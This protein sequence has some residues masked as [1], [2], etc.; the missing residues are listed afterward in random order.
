MLEALRRSTSG[1]VAKIFLGLLVLS[2]AVW[3][4][5]DI[6]TGYRG[7]DVAEVGNTPIT[8]DEFRTSLQQ[9]IQQVSRQV[10]TY[11][12]MDQARSIGLDN[13]VLGRLM[14]EAALNDEAKT[15]GLG[16]TDAVIAE[17]IR[18]DPA[19]QAPGGQFDRSYFEQVLR[20]N[21]FSEAGFV[22]QQ[23]NVLMRQMIAEAVGGEL[24]A[25]E[26]L[27]KAI[28]RF[29]NET[30]SAEFIVITPAM[31]DAVPDPTEEQ[32]RSYY[33]E[34][35]VDF[36]APEYRKV[37]M[38]AIAPAEL[39]NDIEVSEEELRASYD[40]DPSRFGAP[41]R[42]AIERIVFSDAAAAEA[43]RTEIEAGKSF[44]DVAADLGLT[45]EDRKLGTLTKDGILDPAIGEAAFDL[46]I[47]EVSQPVQGTFGPVLVR[48]TE[49]EAGLN[50]SF[51]DVRDEIRIDLATQKAKDQ[52]LDV[53]DAI[54]DDRAAGMTLAEISQKQGLPYREVE[55]IDSNG[56][57]PDESPVSGLPESPQFLSEVLATDIGVEADPLQTRGDGWA[58]L[59][60]LDITPSRDLAF[61]EARDKVAEA[62]RANETRK[63]VEVKAKDIAERVRGGAGF[64]AVAEELGTTSGLVGPIARGAT[65]GPFGTPA[66]QLLF[67]T[68]EGEV[69]STAAAQAPQRVVF[70]V[71]DIDIPPF[72][73]GEAADYKT[74]IEDGISND[75][76][77]Q[78][79]QELEKRIGTSINQEALRVALGE[80]SL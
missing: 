52:I 29:R 24:R 36:R 35:K 10:G 76:L 3:G 63:A 9:E 72:K 67:T 41:E 45:E 20:S 42:R 31:V 79:L 12:T 22:Y 51:E 44:E 56:L 2:F 80:S 40:A 8:I 49:I 77:S 57:A 60:V 39:A 69:N 74:E 38:L 7:T 61:E 70:R 47:G 58:W 75:L 43:A 15:M 48:V 26:V 1:W 78:Y 65:D 62:W 50:K 11:L 55:A 37:A 14:A 27:E 68:P 25:P 21:G 17:S 34:N 66:V 73:P 6:F 23:R 18:R 59:E 13:R 53:Y 71:T 16:V 4:V 64:F 46:E 28:D 54:E 5:A 33:D 19:F 32:L 30:R